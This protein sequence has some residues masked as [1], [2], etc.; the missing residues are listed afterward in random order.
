M[1]V[2]KNTTY[3]SDEVDDFLPIDFIR[4]SS[5]TINLVTKKIWYNVEK[6]SN[7]VEVGTFDAIRFDFDAIRF[8]FGAIRFAAKALRF[9]FVGPR[10][11]RDHR[12]NLREGF[13]FQFGAIRFA[14]EGVA[15]SVIRIVLTPISL[16]IIN[17]EKRFFLSVLFLILKFFLRNPYTRWAMICSRSPG[18]M[19]IT[20][21]SIIV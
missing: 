12:R 15:K 14:S 17:S 20:G 4:K 5:N 6:K 16:P 2:Y 9:P 7:R 19:S 1:G 10:L 13:A 8:D 11:Q 3:F 21:I 18:S